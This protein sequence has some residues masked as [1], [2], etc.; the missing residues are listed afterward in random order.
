VQIDKRRKILQNFSSPGC[1]IVAADTCRTPPA[2]FLKGTCSAS[3]V[4]CFQPAPRA[5]ENVSCRAQKNENNA[6]MAHCKPAANSFTRGVGMISRR[7]L[8]LNRAREITSDQPARFSPN[9]NYRG[10]K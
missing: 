7:I 5:A 2:I 10:E 8:A 3:S 4:A 9:E 1:L 6:I